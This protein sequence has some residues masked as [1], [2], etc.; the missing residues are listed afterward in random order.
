MHAKKTANNQTTKQPN[1]KTPT[2]VNKLTTIVFSSA[3]ASTVAPAGASV[4]WIES[5]RFC[6]D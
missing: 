6:H 4:D 2:K 1:N 5:H 3:V